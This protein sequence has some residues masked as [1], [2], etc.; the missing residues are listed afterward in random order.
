MNEISR[1][2]PVITVSELNR[3]TREIVEGGLPL[4]WVSGEISNFTRAASGHCYF[5]LKDER[6]QV[7]CVLFRHK[8]ARLEFAPEN[9]AQ[10]EVRA[11]PTI[12]EARGEF[13]LGVETMRRAGLGALYEAF[14]RL[15]RKLAAEGL[16]DE[17][18][19]RELPDF[20][21]SLIHI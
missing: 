16:F 14:E 18:R 20:P 12:Y 7:R 9:G 6:A 19:K 13:Q 17:E 11:L 5:S 21:L 2:A 15:R 8:A 3:R 10:V 4:L 1:Q